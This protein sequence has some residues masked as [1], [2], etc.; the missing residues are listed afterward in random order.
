MVSPRGIF[1]L[2]LSIFYMLSEQDRSLVEAYNKGYRVISDKVFSPWRELKPGTR[3]DGY[4]RFCIRNSE[5]K[6]IAILVHRLMG[7]QKYGDEIF[8]EEIEVR[9]LDGNASNNNETNIVIGSP[10]DNALDK[11]PEV[12][13][14]SALSG[15]LATKIHDHESVIAYRNEGHTYDDIMKKFGISSKGTVSY[16]INQSHVLKK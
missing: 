13:L 3:K 8:N 15:S 12:R 14:N 9:H 1:V 10:S 16:I 2:N 6:R 7:Y 4:K 5:G 11:S